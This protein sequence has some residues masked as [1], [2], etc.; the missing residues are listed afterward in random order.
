MQTE[1]SDRVAVY[2]ERVL[3]VLRQ[4]KGGLRLC[5]L[6]VAT[7][8]ARFTLTGVMTQDQLG[9]TKRPGV[10]NSFVRMMKDGT[11]KVYKEREIDKVPSSYSRRNIWWVELGDN[12]PAAEV[13]GPTDDVFVDGRSTVA[14]HDAVDPTDTIN[15]AL[16]VFLEVISTQMDATMAA[17]MEEKNKRIEELTDERDMLKSKLEVNS[18]KVDVKKYFPFF[19]KT[20]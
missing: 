8:L 11:I 18:G 19:K 2:D 10:I 14:Y 7:G 17:K 20:D 16:N 6:S 3:S 1:K 5:D 15:D 13:P 9:T 12:V 4:Y